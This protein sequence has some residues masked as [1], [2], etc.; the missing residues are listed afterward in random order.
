MADKSSEDCALHYYSGITCLLV[1]ST[2]D[3]AMGTV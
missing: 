2:L 1:V 3:M